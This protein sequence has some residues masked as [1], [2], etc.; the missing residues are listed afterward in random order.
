MPNFCHARTWRGIQCSSHRSKHGDLCPQHQRCLD[1]KRELP[2]GLYTSFIDEKDL[3]ARLHR[4]ATCDERTN[5]YWYSR[6]KMWDEA[7]EFPY[8]HTVEDLTE[9][10]FMQCLVYVHD[11]YA[12]NPRQRGSDGIEKGKGPRSFE[13]K[14]DAT[15]MLYC[16]ATLHCFQY[17]AASVCEGFLKVLAGP[18]ISI[19]EATERQLSLIHIS[20]P[21]RPY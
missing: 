13:D 1:R 12:K 7:K 5:L 9:D 21:T 6:H 18:P 11:Y 2:F 8:A 20:E 4:A 3:H 19:Y 15:R 14:D 17:Y 16:G 10:D